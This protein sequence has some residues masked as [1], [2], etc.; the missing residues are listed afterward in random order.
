MN[1]FDVGLKLIEVYEN[2]ITIDQ[3]LL[4]LSFMKFGTQGERVRFNPSLHEAKQDIKTND[5]VIV[6]MYGWFYN[7]TIILK[8]ALVA[9]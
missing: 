7:D 6:I 2:K 5:E 8:K 4:D 3:C 9:K 1:K